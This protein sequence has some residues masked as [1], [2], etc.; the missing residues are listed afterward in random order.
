MVSVFKTLRKGGTGLGW[1]YLWEGA[2]GG[3]VNFMN[4]SKLQRAYSESCSY[5]I[6]AVLGIFI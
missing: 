2:V 1:K 6:N 3:D 5:L 4:I